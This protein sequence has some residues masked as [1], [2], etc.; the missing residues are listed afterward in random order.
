MWLL[1]FNANSLSRAGV[2]A[3]LDAMEVGNFTISRIGLDA[4][5]SAPARFAEEDQGAG[6][7]PP[8]PGDDDD[9]W[10]SDETMRPENPKS[11]NYQM[12]ERLPALQKRNGK[13]NKRVRTAAA[14]AIAP[15]RII[16]HARAPT[17][18]PEGDGDGDVEMAASNTDV[19]MADAAAS[20]S[21]PFMDLPVEVQ[22]VIARHASGD[23]DALSDAQWARLLSHA[24]DRSA[25]RK[26][27]E[28]TASAE[29]RVA[30]THVIGAQE[31]YKMREVRKVRDE[32]LGELQ[33]E[34]WEL[35]NRWYWDR[36]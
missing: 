27:R 22:L 17:P 13:L 28:R 2:T 21:F 33:C 11:M 15:L 18:E 35:A 29:A 34:W 5:N 25:I 31:K 6:Y 8:G 20:T 14:R 10:E 24:S 30:T 7:F 16:L 12:K 23:A 36:L 32:W 4:N 9:V 1:E 19:E 26:L 3:I